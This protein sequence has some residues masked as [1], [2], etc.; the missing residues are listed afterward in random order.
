[1]SNLEKKVNLLV[2]LALAD[3]NTSREELKRALR[4]QLEGEDPIVDKDSRLQEAVNVLLQRAGVPCGLTG[5]DYLVTAICEAVKNRALLRNMTGQF[6]P[7]L[8]KVFNTTP[9]GI[10]RCIRHAVETGWTRG[11]MTLI[12]E[13]F[14]NT[15]S[16]T[17]AKPTNREFI[18][19]LA[20]HARKCWEEF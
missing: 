19:Q 7:Y 3:D 9:N 10:E 12:Y 14:G 8:A 11:D 13:Y 1:M 16:H 6:Y 20:N 18:A 4:A 15:V 5:H 2:E 17:K